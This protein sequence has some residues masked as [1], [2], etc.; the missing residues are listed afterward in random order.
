MTRKDF[1]TYQKWHAAV[2]AEMLRADEQMQI[3][4]GIISDLTGK[5]NRTPICQMRNL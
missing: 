3:Q 4:Q 5:L 1:E 2:F